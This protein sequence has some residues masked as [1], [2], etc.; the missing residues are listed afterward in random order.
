MSTGTVTGTV[1]VAS[2]LR[3]KLCNM[4]RWLESDAGLGKGACG[5]DDILGLI[6]DRS[7]A[8]LT[9]IVV[10]FVSC[11]SVKGGGGGFI[12]TRSFD[13]VIGAIESA[14]LPVDFTRAIKLVSERPDMH[15]RFWN[16]MDLFQQVV[17]DI[18]D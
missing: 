17:A 1:T 14:E 4:V 10:S 11:D 6:S 18:S 5:V 15:E 7:A 8:E 13:G 3:E 2:F 16:Y 9:Y 12:S